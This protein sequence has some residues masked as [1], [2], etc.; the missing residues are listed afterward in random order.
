MA[1][2]HLTIKIITRGA[3]KS[4]VA[5]AAYRSGETL[6]NEYDSVTHDYT[7]KSG[8]FHNEILLPPNAPQEYFNRSVLWNAV[9]KTER[10]KT[11]QLAREIEISLPRELSRDESIDLAR[12]FVKNTFVDK[13]MCADICFHDKD[14]GNNPHA[15]I[16]LTM[17]PIENDGSWGAKSKS[18]NGRKV[19][20]VDW[21][22]RDNAEKWRSSWAD[23]LNEALALKGI[24]E[25]VDHRSYEREGIDQIPTVHMGVAV[26]QMERRGI[27]TERGNYNREID[28]RN[29]QLHSLNARIR[30]LEDWVKEVKTAQ[31]ELAEAFSEIKG[32]HP[33]AET[34]MFIEQNKINSLDDMP[35]AVAQMKDSLNEIRHQYFK[36]SKRLKT[37]E[38]HIQQADIYF[39]TREC[40]QKWSK[41]KE[42]SPQEDDFHKKHRDELD[43]FKTAY[44]YISDVMNGNK[45]IPLEKW[46]KEYAE[47]RERYDLEAVRINKLSDEIKAAERIM[48]GE[49]KRN[50]DR[51]ER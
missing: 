38:K 28:K 43:S 30:K 5:A 36:D 51:G 2:F 11:A 37:L 42:G 25:R 32:L 46:R 1:I 12:R 22:D 29:K 6:R 40:Y 17:R 4:A 19:P 48:R 34:F 41:M 50:T 35:S 8:I 14:K 44:R 13:G 47:L 49:Q 20:T 3:G 9:E 21:N 24:E 45:D 31:P 7:H 26:L 18:I 15:H 10:Y 16:M 39:K 23:Y 33:M 27:V